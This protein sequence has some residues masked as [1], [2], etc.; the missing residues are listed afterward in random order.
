MGLADVSS[1][2]SFPKKSL[3][4][5]D[6]PPRSLA[7]RPSGSWAPRPLSTGARTPRAL[8]P[9]P[10]LGPTASRDRELDGRPPSSTASL[11]VGTRA[12]SSPRARGPP[13]ARRKP[14]RR[15]GARA[16]GLGEAPGPGDVRAGDPAQ[17]L[18]S[19]QVTRL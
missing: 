14:L 12:A 8:R 7:A 4:P 9:T 5:P 19:P 15:R 10:S 1:A 11:P 3:R 16:P 13:G 2:S 18:G 17:E 6:P